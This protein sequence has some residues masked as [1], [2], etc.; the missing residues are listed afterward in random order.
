VLRF[1]VP[2]VFPPEL[3]LTVRSRSV[4]AV[5]PARYQSTRLPGKPL[6]E[7]DGRPMIQHV[8][9]RAQAARLVE[10]VVVATDDERIAGAVDAVGGTAVITRADHLSGTDRLAE[11]AAALAADVIVNVQGDLPFL[12]AEAI[13]D[14]VSL[15]ARRP[16]LPMGTLRRRISDPEEFERASVVKVVVNHDGD[17]L[18]FSRAP[19]PFV[20]PGQPQ[21]HL[22]K[23]V[24]LYVYR[25]AFLLRLAALPPTPLERAESL[26]QL[27]VLEHGFSIGTVEMTADTIEIDTPEDLERGRRLALTAARS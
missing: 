6:V 27:R 2:V 25:R 7:I 9:A 26:E 13:D 17:A 12:P 18:Y 19:I 22:W 10:A 16:A 20:R 21:P 14:A 3:A 5:I 23:H 11:V 24:G 8:L 15:L 4:V 1:A